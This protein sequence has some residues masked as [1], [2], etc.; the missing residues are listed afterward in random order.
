M[1]SLHRDQEYHMNMKR[2]AWLV[3]VLA[4]AAVCWGS[5]RAAQDKDEQ[6]GNQAPVAK[7]ALRSRGSLDQ[8]LAASASQRRLSRGQHHTVVEGWPPRRRR[9]ARKGRRAQDGFGAVVTTAEVRDRN[10]RPPD[11]L[12]GGRV[13]CFETSHPLVA[14]LPLTCDRTR[15]A[16]EGT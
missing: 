3:P 11:D 9:D 13:A 2:K 14:Y 8:G 15:S 7:A 16:T 4:A 10:R 12:S 1:S 6:Q 5:T